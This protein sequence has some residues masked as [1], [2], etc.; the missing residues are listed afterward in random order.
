MSVEQSLN[1]QLEFSLFFIRNSNR[2]TERHSEF[3]KYKNWGEKFTIEKLTILLAMKRK[4]S[5]IYH[6][7]PGKKAKH[8]SGG[9]R[10]AKIF[11]PKQTW[12][13]AI[14]RVQKKT[15]WSL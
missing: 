7:E 9:G 10:S 15:R 11:R 1:T 5:I 12:S 6:F 4:K 3:E 13:I 14:W 8:Q 2:I